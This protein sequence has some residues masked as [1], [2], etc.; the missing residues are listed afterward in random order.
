MQKKN[1]IDIY[2]RMLFSGKNKTKQNENKKQQQKKM[3]D[4]CYHKDIPQ[5]TI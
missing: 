3:T 2:T 5:N 1:V 4:G